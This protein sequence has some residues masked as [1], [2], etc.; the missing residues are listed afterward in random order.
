MEKNE[1]RTVIKHFYI[2]G[3]T[4]KEMKF[5]LDKVLGASA[6]WLKEVLS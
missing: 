3:N 2:K 4:L 5:E 1:F 6:L